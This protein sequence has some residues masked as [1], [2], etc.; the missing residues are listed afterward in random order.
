MFYINREAGRYKETVDEFND[1]AEA[2]KMCSEYQ[3]GEHG[4]AYYY[5]SSSALSNWEKE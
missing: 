2:Y 1:K 4:R 3:L 5:V